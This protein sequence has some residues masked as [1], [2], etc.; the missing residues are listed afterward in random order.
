MKSLGLAEAFLFLS[1]MKPLQHLTVVEFASVLAGP[2]TGSFLAEL[3]ARVIKI[4]NKHTGGD[5]T[6]NWRL[7]NESNKG[8]SAYYA[9][10]NTGKEVVFLNLTEAK[11]YKQAMKLVAKADIV[12][13]NF[14]TNFSTKYKLTFNDFKTVNPT[15][16][17]GNIS[18][19][20]HQPERLA[21]D[22]VLQAETGFMS[23]NGDKNS[24]PTKMP[25]ALIDVHAAH[26][27]KEGLLVA[28]LNKSE[29]AQHV[30]VSLEQAA[31]SSL[32]NQA[33]NWLMNQHIPQRSGSL[34]PNIAPYGEVLTCADGEQL[35]L[36][37][38]SNT[39]FSQL[40]NILNISETINDERFTDNQ[41][42]V[43]IRK[44]LLEILNA[45]ALQ[46]KGQALYAACLQNEIPVGLIKSLDT[47][48]DTEAAQEMIIE[49]TV[50]QQNTQK[51]RNVAFTIS[52]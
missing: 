47:V 10:A 42:R 49:E 45:A 29:K 24:L 28:L 44:E 19:F 4:E 52:N 43:S 18:G 31:I 15:I 23:M 39:Q 6:R 32:V 38:G 40:C 13:T 3:G 14:K 46:F 21:Y 11:D 7:S 37:I 48:F 41:S 17:H 36:A 1:T 16:I 34:H 25:V 22:V 30:N 27:L 33:G 50:A 51:V 2:L 8:V 35:V 20:T 12:L 26:Q 5:V 9:S